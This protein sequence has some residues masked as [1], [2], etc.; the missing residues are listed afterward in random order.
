MPE[1]PAV[2]YQP[3]YRCQSWYEA[4]KKYAKYPL[5]HVLVPY[6]NVISFITLA[7]DGLVS[8]RNK[9]VVHNEDP[10]WGMIFHYCSLGDY[11][12]ECYIQGS[13]ITCYS[14]IHGREYYLTLDQYPQLLDN[15][16]Q[17]FSY[18]IKLSGSQT[19]N[20]VPI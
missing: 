2:H 7:Q 18:L 8:N 6:G 1:E 11:W 20:G 13:K 3:S 4:T 10:S 14:I 5:D 15:M 12:Y 17:P 9:Y 16:Y 19:K